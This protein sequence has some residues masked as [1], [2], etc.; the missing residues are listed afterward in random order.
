[1]KFIFWILIGILVYW[2]FTKKKNITEMVLDENCGKYINKNSAI[3]LEING[4]EYYFC[5]E[6]CVQEFLKKNQ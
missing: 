1:M 4:K 3:K 5:S 6:K 2:Y